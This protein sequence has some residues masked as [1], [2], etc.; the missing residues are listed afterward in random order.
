M[1]QSCNSTDTHI[2]EPKSIKISF[3]S[4]SSIFIATQ[5]KLTLNITTPISFLCWKT[6]TALLNRLS[7]NNA[8]IT[9]DDVFRKV[10]TPTIKFFLNLFL[11]KTWVNQET[12][13]RFQT[14]TFGLSANRLRNFIRAST[15]LSGI[16]R[17]MLPT[18]FIKLK[19]FLTIEKMV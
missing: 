15:R 16:T 3:Q 8:C 13:R 18:S 14:L 5:N 6:V 7:R 1:I 4:I 12:I 10:E 19:F 17:V 2:L 9:R 11:K